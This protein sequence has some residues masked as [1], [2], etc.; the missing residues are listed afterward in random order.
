M[1]AFQIARKGLNELHGNREFRS[2]AREAMHVFVTAL[3]TAKP[4]RHQSRAHLW[5]RNEFQISRIRK[6]SEDL[7]DRMKEPSFGD[8][9]HGR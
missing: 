6:E 8:E 2:G 9:E 1:R 5:S 3:R 7:L 4:C